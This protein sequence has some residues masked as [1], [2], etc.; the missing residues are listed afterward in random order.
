MAECV[1]SNLFASADGKPPL[2]PVA[3]TPWLRQGVKGA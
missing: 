1:V 3:E 2:N